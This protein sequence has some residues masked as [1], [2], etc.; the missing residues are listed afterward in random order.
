MREKER[1]KAVAVRYE[2]G[3]EA[4]RIL[5]KGTNNNAQRI[6]TLAKDYNID[7]I[8]DEGLTEALY[9]TPVEGMIPGELFPVMAEILAA[10]MAGEAK[11]GE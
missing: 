7:I 4:P 11:M 9:L 5:A 8:E 6:K 3:D 10:V 2:M 1:E